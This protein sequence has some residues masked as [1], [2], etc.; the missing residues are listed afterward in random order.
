M[1]FGDK[2]V[3]GCV[4]STPN[5]GLMKANMS[6]TISIIFDFALPCCCLNETLFLV[7]L[8]PPHKLKVPYKLLKLHKHDVL[9]IP[10]KEDYQQLSYN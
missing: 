4:N 8:T 5:F 6:N 10:L 3:R 1:S 2:D 7:K 9:G